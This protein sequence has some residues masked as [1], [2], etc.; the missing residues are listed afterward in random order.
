MGVPGLGARHLEALEICVDEGLRPL[1]EVVRGNLGTLAYYAG[2]WTEAARVVPDGAR[3]RDGGRQG[4]RRG[5]DRR[6]PRR[7]AH[8]PGPTS[9]RRRPL[10]ADALR[11][12]RASGAA[13][14][15]RRRARCSW[16]GVHLIR[17]DHAGG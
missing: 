1:E 2:R 14:V 11:V 5:R 12:L 6:Q 3:G 17:G 10:L 4:L 15:P 13:L 8:Q 7:A 16:P 9:T